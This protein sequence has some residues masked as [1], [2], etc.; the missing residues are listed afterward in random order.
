[1]NGITSIPP[2]KAIDAD[3]GATL[4]QFNI[5]IEEMQL[6]F[7]LAFRKSDGTAYAPTEAEKKAMTLLR[8]GR[9][10]KRLFTH[11]GDVQ[12]ADSF[13][14]AVKKV[15]DQLGERTNKIVQRNILLSNFPQ[16]SKSFEKWSTEISEAAKLIDYTNYDWKQAAVDAMILQTSSKKLRE[17]ALAENTTYEEL[18][19]LG[20][21]KE[22]SEKGAALLERAAG[23][24]HQEPDINEEVRRLKIENKR[25]KK[26]KKSR[27]DQNNS[28][29][30]KKPCHR[31]TSTS[32]NGDRDCPTMGKQ[33]SK[34]R[35]MNH[36]GRACTNTNFQADHTTRR[37]D[38]EE[39]TDSETSNRIIEVN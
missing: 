5:Y 17:K 25:L 22:Q 11:V 37:V 20:I 26:K 30:N 29:Q 27:T 33:C 24:S 34:C 39:D 7:T 1:M 10:M 15:Q 8:G 28:H 19:K 36:F 12:D 2:F 32:C 31:C 14:A 3:P 38:S 16:G 18:L 21:A 9:D 23:G 35:K 13:D 6:L 4:E